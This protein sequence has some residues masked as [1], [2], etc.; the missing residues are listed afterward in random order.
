MAEGLRS[1]GASVRAGEPLLCLH[2]EGEEKTILVSPLDGVLRGLIRSGIR[3][4][5]G[6]KVADI[7]PRGDPSHCFS[8]SDK[9]LAVAGGVLEAILSRESVMERT[10]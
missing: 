7:D 2:G 6:L 1:L 10:R 8:A 9:A 3:V 5:A 4:R